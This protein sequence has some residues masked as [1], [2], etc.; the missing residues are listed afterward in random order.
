[1]LDPVEL[2]L[3]I[4]KRDMLSKLV[5][6]KDTKI[7]WPGARA[8]AAHGDRTRHPKRLRR[9]ASR[10]PT[11]QDLFAA[12]EPERVSSNAFGLAA[13]ALCSGPSWEI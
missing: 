5:R 8:I 10:Y 1:M 13:D 2:L 9:L 12:L 3:V 4:Q 7:D 6:D 11:R